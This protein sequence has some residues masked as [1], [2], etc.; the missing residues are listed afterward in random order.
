MKYKKYEQLSFVLFMSTMI[1]ILELLFLIFIIT[2]KEYNYK[3]CTGIVMKK[4]R[5]MLIISKKDKEILYKNKYLYVRDIKKA[6]KIVEDKNI[7]ITNDNK[8]YYEVI[9]NY[10]FEKNY[11][12]ND[13]ISV[14]IKN[15]KYRLIEMFKLIWD[16]DKNRKD[17]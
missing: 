4:D 14:T 9:I 16:G 2:N 13:T 7:E 1:I 15:R 12:V 8:R 10:K 11:R 5:L 3:I 17:K 6:Y